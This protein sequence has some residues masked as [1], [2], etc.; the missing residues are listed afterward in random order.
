[1]ENPKNLFK[2]AIHAGRPQIGI[3]NTVGGPVIVEQ[4]ALAGFDWVLIDTEHSPLEPVDVL[5][6]L[7]AVAGYPAT[8]AVVRI[9]VNDTALIKRHLDM[10]VQTLLIPY[11]ESAEEARAAVAAMRYPPRGVRGMAGIT[12]ATRYGRVAHYAT[13]AEEELCLLVQVESARALADIE[14]IATVDGV[15]GVFIG[16]ADLSASMGYPG[17]PGHPDVV[18]AIEGAIA[19]LNRLGVPAG[20]LSLDE[21][22]T[23]RCMDLGTVFTAVGVDLALLDRAV[24]DLAARFLPPDRA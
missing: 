11:V 13:R 22:F 3:W 12:R 18:A 19:T 7:Q 14:A 16:P 2:A 24:R 4:L 17:N 5:P 6:S 23:R 21:A 8:S 9:V 20:I 15:D 1:M 10:G